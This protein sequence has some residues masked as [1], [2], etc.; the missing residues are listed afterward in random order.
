MEQMKI[1]PY[2]IDE[3]RI[4]G[5]YEILL[6][7]K[8]KLVEYNKKNDNEIYEYFLPE[9]RNYLLW[10]FNL[11][12]NA[13]NTS[14]EFNKMSNDLKACTCGNYYCNIFKKGNSIIICFNTGI[15]FAISN[16]EKEIKKIKKYEK[17]IELETINFRNEKYYTIPEKI[18]KENITE[19]NPRLI[20]YVLQIY[21]Q[22]Y[23]NKI[24]KEM[25]SEENFRRSRISFEKFTEKIFNIDETDLEEEKNIIENWKKEL[26]L[27]EIYIK[28]DNQ[29]DLLYK[30]N[31]LN[32][33]SDLVKFSIALFIV[34]I[35]LGIINL[36]SMI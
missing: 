23:L 2:I 8:Y 6:D 16:D 26:K 14:T 7:N 4:A 1:Y 32:Y 31:K 28:V 19:K 15:C 9:I 29:F 36:W 35:I 20:A 30:N 24:Q 18:E 17:I 5:Y 10:T 25:Q 27:E 22:I 12:E 3:K 33:N 34:A 13:Q 21:K 11:G